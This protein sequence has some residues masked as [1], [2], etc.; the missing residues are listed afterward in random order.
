MSLLNVSLIP[1][2]TLKTQCLSRLAPAP[3]GLLR[4]TVQP[5]VSGQGH[6]RCVSKGLEGNPIRPL[7]CGAVEP[8]PGPNRQTI[9]SILTEYAVCV[10]MLCV[11]ALSVCLSA[12]LC[13]CV[14]A[15]VDSVLL[16]DLAL[17]SGGAI[18]SSQRRELN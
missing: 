14:S 12:C 13:V 10:C 5:S 2:L 6:S 18:N 3:L 4:S 1:L 7:V 15:C 17:S 11:Y 8:L 16:T 9:L